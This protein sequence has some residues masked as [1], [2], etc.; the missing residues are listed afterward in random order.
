M[1]EV[2]GVKT[3][4]PGKEFPEGGNLFTEGV[5][6]KEVFS[7]VDDRLVQGFAGIARFETELARGF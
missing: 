2:D 3:P 1:P 5:A 4:Q 6:A 7:Q